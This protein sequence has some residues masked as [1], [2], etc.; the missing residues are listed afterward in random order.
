MDM[1]TYPNTYPYPGY[2]FGTWQQDK[3]D[4]TESHIEIIWN[5]LPLQK[6]ICR[7]RH[8]TENFCIYLCLFVLYHSSYKAFGRYLLSFL[9]LNFCEA[10]HAFVSLAVL[11]CHG[12][13]WCSMSTS[14]VPIFS[15]ILILIPVHLPSC[16]STSFSL[17]AS[18]PPGVYGTNMTE[19]N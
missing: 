16:V 3:Q 11:P 2:R 10:K 9:C 5:S 17:L 15:T 13:A 6:N 18:S 14:L 7:R 4:K 1:D 19:T 8:S 12:S